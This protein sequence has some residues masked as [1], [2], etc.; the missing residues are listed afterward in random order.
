MGSSCSAIVSLTGVE[1][2]RVDG[3]EKA[4]RRM[5]TL[6]VSLGRAE[7]ERSYLDPQLIIINPVSF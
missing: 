7:V 4:G 2:R 3:D 5:D 1:S 6:D